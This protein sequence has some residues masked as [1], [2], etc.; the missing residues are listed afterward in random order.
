MSVL[1]DVDELIHIFQQPNNNKQQNLRI[2]SVEML[3]LILKWM[4]LKYSLRKFDRNWEP[5]IKKVFNHLFANYKSSDNIY[6]STDEIRYLNS[7]KSILRKYILQLEKK[8]NYVTFY[9]RINLLNKSDCLTN[10]NHMNSTQK[11][12]WQSQQIKKK[13][14]YKTYAVNIN[15]Y[16]HSR[17]Q[18]MYKIKTKRNLKKKKRNMLNNYSKQLQIESIET[19]IHN[20]NTENINIPGWWQCNICTEINCKQSIFCSICKTQNEKN[21][22]I[23]VNIPFWRCNI[24]TQIN[25]KQSV[26]CSICKRKALHHSRLMTSNKSDSL[27]YLICGYMQLSICNDIISIIRLYIA[28]CSLLPEYSMKCIAATHLVASK[29]YQY[30]NYKPNRCEF[31]DELSKD[32]LKYIY[33]RGGAARDCCLLRKIKDINIV[34]DINTLNKRYLHHL[35]TYHS[36]FHRANTNCIFYRHYLNQFHLKSRGTKIHNKVKSLGQFD[37]TN[38]RHHFGP[39][40]SGVNAF[41]KESV[42]NKIHNYGARISNCDWVINS[43]FFFNI[44]LE[45]DLQLA[46]A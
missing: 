23:N 43:R 28:Y 34:I 33:V 44:L 2:L 41:L 11:N 31:N 45:S 26:F 20:N 12:K 37:A 30:L 42:A 27:D 16:K 22:S 18:K 15:K 9:D 32:L 4:K 24:C 25:C 17:K 35:K 1:L 29:I 21:T 3:E 13:K 19:H 8:F 36:S 46:K 7:N 10:I 40:A 39:Y 38:R 14:V 5:K 6:L